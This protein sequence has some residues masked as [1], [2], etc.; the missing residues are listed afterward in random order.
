MKLGDLVRYRDDWIH[1]NHKYDDNGVATDW[2]VIYPRA[3]DEGWSGPC[4]ILD[5]LEP[6]LWVV[7]DGGDRVVISHEEGLTAIEVI[8]LE[9]EIEELAMNFTED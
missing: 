8:G 3:D 4:L 2:D 9:R 5:Q 1:A 7:L 6:G